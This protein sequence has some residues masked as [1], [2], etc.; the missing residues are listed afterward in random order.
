MIVTGDEH[1]S[2][3]RIREEITALMFAALINLERDIH[4]IM[5]ESG[6]SWEEDEWLEET[7]D[8]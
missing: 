3:E 8:S 6:V 5:I 1:G 7:P 2:E 4:R